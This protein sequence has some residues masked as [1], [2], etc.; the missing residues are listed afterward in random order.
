IT[1]TTKYDRT[2]LLG[3]QV[4]WVLDPFTV[5][6]GMIDSTGGA[7]IDYQ[8]NPRIAMTGE[9]FD[10]GK[11]RDPNPHL[12]FSGQYVVRRETPRTP[13]IFVSG[14]V[15]NPL[16]KNSRAVTF[17]GGIRWRDDDLKYL[18]SSVPIGK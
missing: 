6:L 16:N 18:L 17:G 7:A 12:R 1:D 4:G 3:A 13:L 10:F 9:A 14:G 2:F 5:R 8:F 15:D 11:K